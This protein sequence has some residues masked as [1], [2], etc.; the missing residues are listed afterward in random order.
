MI[1]MSAKIP[2][3]FGRFL[4]RMFNLKFQPRCGV[5]EWFFRLSQLIK[6]YITVS[7][8]R[9]SCFT[10][11]HVQ[12]NNFT[13][14]YRVN[15]QNQTVFVI[16]CQDKPAVRAEAFTLF[17][18]LSRF[19]NGPSKGPFLEQ[20]HANF[21]SLLIHMNEEPEVTKVCFPK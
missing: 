18:N 5:N 6:C 14:K 4:K 12:T 11:F 9:F 13:F 21:V 20:I 2:T 16:F 1:G 3:I 17:G 8:Q 15:L 7:Q 10:V 19:G